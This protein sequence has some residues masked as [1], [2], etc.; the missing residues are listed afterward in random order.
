MTCKYQYTM[1]YRGQKNF[2][3]YQCDVED[4]KKWFAKTKEFVTAV[5]VELQNGEKWIWSAT[6]AKICYAEKAY[7]YRGGKNGWQRVCSPKSA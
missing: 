2:G 1:K 7:R 5:I 6:M 4:F 3:E